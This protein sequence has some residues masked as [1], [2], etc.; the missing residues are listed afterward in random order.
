MASERLSVCRPLLPTQAD[1]APYL[2][3]ID[4]ARWYSNFGPLYVRLTERL[5]EARGVT[6]DQVVI[7]ANA[8]V[9]LTLSLA[10][11]GATEGYCLVPAWTFAA[12]PM[13]V[14]AAGL[15][16]YFVDV[17]RS[18]WA[19]TSA[20]AERSLDAAPGPVVAVMPVAPFG[21]PVAPEEW[22]RFT[23]RTGI[24]AVIDAAAGFDALT[25]G[26][27]P[28]VVSLHATKALGIGEG[29]AVF[30]TD[31]EHVARIRQLANFGLHGSRL[32][33]VSG[34]NAKVS[35]YTC[36]VGMAAMDQWPSRRELYIERA[37]R[38]QQA[39]GAEVEFQPNF[40]KFASATCVIWAAG[41]DADVL[42]TTLHEDGIES[43]RWWPAV[44][45]DHPAFQGSAAGDMSVARLAAAQSLGLP[46]SVTLRLDDVDRVAAAVKR[47]LRRN[48][49]R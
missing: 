43:L 20:I 19:L 7:V 34:T 33:A 12:T 29:G 31:R 13:A 38:Y 45:P 39:L 2:R 1:L 24:P 36:A 22:E 30:C 25:V 9:G 3:E 4:N 32:A 6:A 10:A 23:E 17:D 47:H 15:K 40:G 16:P 21:A 28:S 27:A 41:V 35:E 44:C 42:Q 14:E 49:P 48:E 46:M 5:A 8:T 26:R 18:S 11:T 37:E